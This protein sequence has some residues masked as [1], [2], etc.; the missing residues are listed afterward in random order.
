[1]IELIDPTKIKILVTDDNEVNLKII[2]AILKKN[3]Y[4]AIAAIDGAVCIELAK[5]HKPDIILLDINMPQIDG[6]EACKILKQDELT[7]NSI[8][9]FVTAATDARTL[10]SAFEAGGSDYVK[11][12]LNKTELL[13]R[14]KSALTQKML[15]NIFLEQE[16]LAGV[17]EMAGAISL[18]LTKPMET[19]LSNIEF[20]SSKIKPENNFYN[21]FTKIKKQYV[22]MRQIVSKLMNITKYETKDYIK[23]KKII[24]LDKASSGGMVI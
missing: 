5:I 7:K 23:G 18:E 15:T 13:A 21:D 6:I 17:L 22:R 12:P 10:Q 9:I 11:I 19:I 3:G 2:T 4:N 8:I 20:I 16:K 14:I 24:D 1:M